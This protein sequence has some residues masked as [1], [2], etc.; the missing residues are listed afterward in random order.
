M[1]P[2][3][4]PEGLRAR[5]DEDYL[6]AQY[7]RERDDELITPIC[8]HL[9][10]YVE[11]SIKSRLMELELPYG[12]THDLLLLTQMLPNGKDIEAA[13]GDDLIALTHFATTAK[14]SA[15]APNYDEMDRAFKAAPKIVSMV[16]QEE[17]RASDT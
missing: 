13:Y 11:K 14:Y 15:R 3:E 5:A 7:L 6:V 17:R 8:F 2:L 1:E 12:K 9:Q 16:L 10:Q 4:T